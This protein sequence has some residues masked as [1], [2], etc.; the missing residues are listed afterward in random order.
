MSRPLSMLVSILKKAGEKKAEQAS[1]RPSDSP[2]IRN[3]PRDAR[4]PKEA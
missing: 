4:A 3:L 2:A 1:L